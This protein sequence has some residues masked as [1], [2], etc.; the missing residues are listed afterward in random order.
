MKCVWPAGNLP[1]DASD[2]ELDIMSQKSAAQVT[3]VLFESICWF[4]FPA[5][6]RDTV[7]TQDVN[8]LL[9]FLRLKYLGE[10]FA[11]IEIPP[12]K[13]PESKKKRS[14]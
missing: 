11:S 8:S 6:Q 14:T 10:S 13:N 2:L 9:I 7:S 5:K 3:T 4:V 1:G 12:I